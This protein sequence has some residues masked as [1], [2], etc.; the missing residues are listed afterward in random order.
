MNSKSNS[1]RRQ[2]YNDVYARKSEPSGRSSYRH[3]NSHTGDFSFNN[4]GVP[5]YASYGNDGQSK[6]NGQ[7]RSGGPWSDG[8]PRSGEPWNKG[9]SSRNN[10][11]TQEDFE[12]LCRNIGDTV[13]QMSK[14]VGKHLSEAGN[15]MGS[16][17]EQAAKDY[18]QKVANGDVFQNPVQLSRAKK[19]LMRS[20]FRGTGGLTTS[21]VVMTSFGGLFTFSFAA[22]LI[23]EAGTGVLWAD[24]AGGGPFAAALFGTSVF[25]GL[26]AWLL[27]AG[28][29]RLSAARNLKDIQRIMGGR[30]FCNISELALHMQKTEKKTLAAIYDLLKRGMLPEGHLTDDETCLIVTNEAYHHYR[31]AQ[32]TLH[33]KQM[34]KKRL[35]EEK[36]REALLNP[37]APVPDDVKSFVACGNDYI[38]QMK[39]LDDQINDEAVSKKVRAIEELVAKIMQRVTDEPSVIDGLEHL[40][41]YYLPTTVKLLSA[42]DDLEEQPV[43]GENIASSRREIEQTLDVLQGAYEKLLDA[44]FQDLSMDVSSD[45]SVLNAMLAQEGLTDSP[46]DAKMNT[47]KH[48]DQ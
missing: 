47:E 46:F 13:S 19:G 4:S 6:N 5:F 14:V 34:E 10:D 38:R 31:Q 15:A 40:M 1:D 29:K 2:A 27:S 39:A 25:L 32:R 43:Q 45:I 7:P 44:T 17:I 35:E 16:A 36:R 26:S 9:H 3:D 21:G 48:T 41:D 8:Q 28:M 30:E 20:R 23:A 22:G 37:A 33:Q 24:V 18:K 42:Y 11:F 12:R